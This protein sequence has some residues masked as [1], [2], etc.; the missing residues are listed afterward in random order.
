MKSSLF[1]NTILLGGATS[2]NVEAAR[3]AGFDQIELWRLD[4]EPVPEGPGAVR[5]PVPGDNAGFTAYHAFL[6]FDGAPWDRP[7]APRRRPCWTRR[8]AWARRPFWRPRPSTAKV[9]GAW[10]RGSM[11]GR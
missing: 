4:V 11:F 9:F 3:A 1:L 6:D 10:R 5:E 7:S 8:F 2:A